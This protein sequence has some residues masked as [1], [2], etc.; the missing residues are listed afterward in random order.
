MFDV[1]NCSFG[2]YEART[3]A[4]GHE[5]AAAELRKGQEAIA[6]AFHDLAASMRG[7]PRPETR[8]EKFERWKREHP[9]EVMAI[10][11]AAA[12]WGGGPVL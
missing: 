2:I 9:A 5:K 8:I 3:I 6:D 4:E 7:E 12:L 11:A 1:T 10:N